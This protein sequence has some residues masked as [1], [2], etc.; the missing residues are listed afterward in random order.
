MCVCVCVC[1]QRSTRSWTACVIQHAR[2]SVQ[3]RLKQE[4]CAHTPPCIIM[5]AMHTARHKSEPPSRTYFCLQTVSLLADPPSR[6]CRIPRA[7]S[8]S[9][10]GTLRPFLERTPPTPLRHTAE[11][12]GVRREPNHCAA[13]IARASLQRSAP[14]PQTLAARASLIPSPAPSSCANCRPRIAFLRGDSEGV[15]GK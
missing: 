12:R 1:V 9:P 11:T 4:A 8:S 10:H 5:C 2:R 6:L 15:N 14:P 3:R 13:R 7:L